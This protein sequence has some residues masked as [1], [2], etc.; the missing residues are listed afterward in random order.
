MRVNVVNPGSMGPEPGARHFL[1]VVD[2]AAKSALRALLLGCV[3]PSVSLWE[4]TP[5]VSDDCFPDRPE[6]GVFTHL[7]ENKS[8]F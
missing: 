3:N 1:P 4:L 2:P 8:P 7:G 6:R 5:E